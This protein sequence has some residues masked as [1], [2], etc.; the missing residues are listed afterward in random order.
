MIEKILAILELIE[1]EAALE[2]IYWFAERRLVQEPV[3]EEPTHGQ[4][5]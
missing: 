3:K 2:A 4:T 5:A 1:D